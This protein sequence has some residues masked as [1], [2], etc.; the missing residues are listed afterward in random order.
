MA[1]TFHEHLPY[2]R[3]DVGDMS[4]RISTWLWQ[5]D[6]P[7]ALLVRWT[8]TD[9]AW[10]VSRDLIALGLHEPTGMGD[11]RV[12]PDGYQVHIGLS[13]P[14]GVARLTFPRIRVTTYIETTER[15][16]PPHHEHRWFDIDAEIARLGVG[17]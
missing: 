15:M 9:P 5:A 2:T 14:S 12:V 1:P 7:F 4:R 6:C 11:V 16:V 10:V 3:P 17:S 13:S 8:P